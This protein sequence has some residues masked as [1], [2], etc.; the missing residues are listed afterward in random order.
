MNIPRLQHLITILENVPAD[1][2]DLAAWACGTTAC[3]C[4]WASQDPQF[5]AEGFTLYREKLD[6]EDAWVAYPIFVLGGT[7]LEGFRAVHAFFDLDDE[8]ADDLFLLRLYHERDIPNPTPQ[9]VIN[10]IKEY[11]A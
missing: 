6:Y 8:T 7:K 5:N 9:D 2:F 10:R 11:L 3:A 1:H 4:G